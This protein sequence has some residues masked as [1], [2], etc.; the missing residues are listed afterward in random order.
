MADA[1]IF[2][3]AVDQNTGRLRALDPASVAA[4]ATPTS[5]TIR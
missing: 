3:V 1:K 4:G 5:I 2:Q